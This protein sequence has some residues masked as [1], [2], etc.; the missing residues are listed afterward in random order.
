MLL[1]VVVLHDSDDIGVDVIVAVVVCLIACLGDIAL[2][3]L[4]ALQPL[5]C[6]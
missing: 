3:I 6:Y 4:V 2:A 5:Q 1:F